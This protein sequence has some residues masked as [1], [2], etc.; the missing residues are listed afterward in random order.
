MNTFLTR[1][2]IA[3]TTTLTEISGNNPEQIYQ[4]FSYQNKSD[5]SELGKKESTGTLAFYAT[6]NA[7]SALPQDGALLIFIDRKINDEDLAGHTGIVRKK[8]IK[9]RCLIKINLSPIDLKCN[10][11]IVLMNN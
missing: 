1:I 9:V 10:Q 7:I 2:C 6:L 3:G 4:F 8:N 11:C 5:N